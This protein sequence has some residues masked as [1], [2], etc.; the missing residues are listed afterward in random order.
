MR[1]RWI[2]TAATAAVLSGIF[3]LR[4]GAAET[5]ASAGAAP[6]TQFDVLVSGTAHQALYDIAVDG[7]SGIAVGALGAVLETHDGGKSW[8]PAGK[9]P[10]GQA[11]LGADLRGDRAIVV[12]QA[13]MVFRR[14]GTGPWER[15]DSGTDKRLFSV[16]SNSHGLAFAVG[17][18]GTVIASSDDGKL[19]KPV[20]FDWKAY[21]KDAVE[22]HL[23]KVF[24]GEDGSV[25]LVGEFELIL[26]SVDG[27]R[28]WTLLHK[29]E[30]SLFDLELRGDGVGFAVGQKGKMLRTADHGAT[31]AAVDTGS[32]AVLL[33]VCSS[34]KGRIVVTGMREMISS[35]DDGR[36]WHK[37][38]AGDA[39]TNWYQ[40]IAPSPDTGTAIIVGHSGRIV[41]LRI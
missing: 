16:S 29:G 28:K 10:M 35:V 12:G 23:Y 18:F 17:G 15:A 3:P 7:S 37:V 11:L 31:W 30:A 4:P 19:W 5:A 26:R 14:V 6:D 9:A 32:D 27:G 2:V 39:I 22:P 21:L 34:L 33:G 20:A 40:G 38:T 25:T 1:A 36:T 24:V 13:G 41:R 8:S